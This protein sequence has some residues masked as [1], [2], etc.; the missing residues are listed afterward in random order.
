MAVI[1][2]PLFSNKAACTL[3]SLL[4]HKS[5]HFKTTKLLSFV[6]VCHLKWKKSNV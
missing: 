3:Q 6:V 4:K 2:S 1:L 5:T